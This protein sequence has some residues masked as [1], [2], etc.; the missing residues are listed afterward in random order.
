MWPEI[1]WCGWGTKRAMIGKRGL[2]LLLMIAWGLSACQAATLTVTTTPA[3][4]HTLTVTATATY[5]PVPT[6]TAT[7]TLPTVSP[8]ISPALQERPVFLAWPLPAD[9]GLA[10]I[11]QYPN[12]AWSWNYLGLNAGYQCPLAFGYLLNLDSLLYWRD[13]SIPEAQD[14]AQADPHNFEMVEC[15]SSGGPIGLTGHEG[16]DIK[17][18]PGTPVYAAADGKVQD[19]HL[20]GLNTRIVLKHCLGGA[21]NENNECIGGK[22]WY[23]TYMHIVTNK[24]LLATNKIVMQGTQ[25][26][27]IYDQTINSHL[28][29]EVGLDKRSYTNFKNPWG[30]DSAPWLGC[31]WID[32]LLCP[33]PD[34]V[35]KRIAVYSM[36]ERLVIQ[37]GGEKPVEVLNALDI[38]KI[39]L[40][41]GRIAVMDA[42]SHLRI[43]ED[44]GAQPVPDDLADWTLAASNILD[45]QI[46]AHRVAVLD[47]RKNLLAKENGLDGDW[48]LQAENIQAFSVSEHRI[49]YLTTNGDLFVKEGDLQQ[50][51]VALAKNV[52]AFQLNDNHIAIVNQ[53]GTLFVNEGEIFAEWQ[54]MAEHV[55]AFQLTNL[56]V[57]VLDADRNLLVKEGNLRAEWLFQAKNVVS[58]QLAD[59]RMLMQADGEPF[60]YKEGNLYQAWAGLS[61]GLK[62]AIL[63]AD[64][65]V[66]IP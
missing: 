8:T 33:N 40:M 21:W 7:A 35:Y 44:D 25:V 45:F 26:G 41:G 32:Q 1:Y 34:P 13:V 66:Y 12:T 59:Y 6:L 52:A 3:P 47:V 30:S 61:A 27:T 54:K 22:Q 20:N 16:T 57:G 28:H 50:G 29:F 42:K 64:T 5:T 58:F 53:A 55:K 15:Y 60:K 63:N 14:K 37:R 11:S 4:T 31:L 56:R 46:T 23:T 18:S 9:I 51:W 36:T 19:W 65:P 10:R 24:D 2:F 48:L 43:R 17:A 39:R 62:S 49:G 38:Q